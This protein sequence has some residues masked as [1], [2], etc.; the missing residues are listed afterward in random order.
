MAAE[1]SP[2]FQFYPK[3]FLTDGNVAVMSLEERGA[4]I[5]LLCLCW[6]ECSLP[7]DTKRLAQIVGVPQRIF[8]RIWPAIKVCFT[9]RD[10][11]RFIQGRLEKERAKQDAYRRRQSDAGKA[12]AAARQPD[13]NHGSTVQQ[14]DTND[15]AT[16][17]STKSKSPISVSNLRSPISDSVRKVLSSAD[18]DFERFRAAYP[19]SRRIGGKIGRKAFHNALKA[20]SL[21]QMLTALEQQKRSEQIG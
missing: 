15:E 13:G 11:G 6:Q 17:Q 3:D 20:A 9:Q 19:V 21:D 16:E 4:Y 12:S 2:A 1:S 14:P 7:N 5:T 8:L 18:A 10:D